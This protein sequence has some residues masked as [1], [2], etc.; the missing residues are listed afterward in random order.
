[1]ASINA[2][3]FSAAE[4]ASWKV[5][6]CLESNVNR[7]GFISGAV[8]F[9]II[10]G[11]NV[12]ITDSNNAGTSFEVTDIRTLTQPKIQNYRDGEVVRLVGAAKKGSI[13][14]YKREALEEVSVEEIY[15]SI[16]VEDGEM[17]ASENPRSRTC[18]NLNQ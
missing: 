2:S 16:S 5:T 3:G 18:Q 14:L 11:S 4:P 17:V 6:A 13:T 8:E 15:T 12:R 10:E 9:A 1:V 7:E